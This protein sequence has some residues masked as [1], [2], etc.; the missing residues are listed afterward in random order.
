[1]FAGE[2]ASARGFDMVSRG[3]DVEF[4]FKSSA[5]INTEFVSQ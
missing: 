4:T 1:M 3:L 5:L 2:N